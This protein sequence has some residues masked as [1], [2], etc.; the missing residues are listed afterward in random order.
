MGVTRD[1][2]AIIQACKKGKPANCMIASLSE[3]IGPLVSL[4]LCTSETTILVTP[5]IK[6]LTRSKGRA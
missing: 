3:R 6:I 5:R 2:G 4:I 1:G